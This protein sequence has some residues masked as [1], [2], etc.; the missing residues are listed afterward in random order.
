MEFQDWFKAYEI[1]LNKEWANANMQD[2]LIFCR[3]K[4]KEESK[5]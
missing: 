2:F 4:H 1:E 3:H 5:Q